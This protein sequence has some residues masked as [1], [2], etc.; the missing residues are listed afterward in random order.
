MSEGQTKNM[1][2]ELEIQVRTDSGQK[3]EHQVD[4]MH[5]GDRNF[6]ISHQPKDSEI[7]AKVRFRILSDGDSQLDAQ[8]TSGLMLD[9]SITSEEGNAREVIVRTELAE[10]TSLCIVTIVVPEGTVIRDVNTST[11]IYQE[12]PK[13]KSR[14]HKTGRLS[15]IVVVDVSART[16]DYQ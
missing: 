9:V 10:C 11:Q 6:K 12:R 14:L 7:D 1:V 4:L 13:K 16:P 2:P 15:R 3:P 8:L 5:I